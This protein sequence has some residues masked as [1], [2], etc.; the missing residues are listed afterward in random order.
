MEKIQIK[1]R[2]ITQTV[3][4]WLTAILTAPL[5]A[6][7]G[8]GG[9]KVSNP[10]PNN[11]GQVRPSGQVNPGTRPEVKKGLS[12]GQKVAILAGA[13]ALFYLYKQHQNKKEQGPQGK[14]YL[15]KNGRIYYRDAQGKPQWVTPP[16][17]G[18][19]V[20]EAEAQQYRDFQGY[21]NQSTGRDLTNVAPAQ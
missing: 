15:S 10:Q 4:I 6:S 9:G 16:K 19:K 12:T 7:C 1:H 11:P 14:Y 18:I 20:P 2:K 5:F 3:A 13:A 21:N 8:G 17:D